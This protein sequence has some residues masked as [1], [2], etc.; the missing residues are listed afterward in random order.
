M[1]RLEVALS[2]FGFTGDNTIG[3]PCGSLLLRA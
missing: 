1:S 2:G 3:K